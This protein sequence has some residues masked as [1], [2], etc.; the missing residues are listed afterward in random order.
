MAIVVVPVQVAPNAGVAPSGIAMSTGNTY[1]VRNNGK[2][3]LHFL[4]T[5]SNTANVTIITQKTVGGYAVSDQVVVVVA[6]T[7]DMFVNIS[8][9]DVFN[10]ASGDVSI[11]TDE[12]TSL[13]IDAIGL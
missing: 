6:T 3:L 1:T 5:G 8:N 12:G 7:G 2:V 11:T 10:D 9:R 13:T 4:K